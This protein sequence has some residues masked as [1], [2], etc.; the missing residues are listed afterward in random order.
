[1]RGKRALPQTS[2]ERGSPPQPASQERR[3]PKPSKRDHLLPQQPLLP[4]PPARKEQG[5]P[6]L[7]QTKAALPAWCFEHPGQGEREPQRLAGS[8]P[9][10]PSFGQA[11]LA[12]ALRDKMGVKR[13]EHVVPLHQPM[14]PLSERRK[15]GGETT[16]DSL[17]TLL[18]SPSAL[19]PVRPRAGTCFCC[20]PGQRAERLHH[21]AAINAA[22]ERGRAERSRPSEPLRALGR[23]FLSR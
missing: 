8:S 1:M 11:A 2:G 3:A 15:E 22:A 10:P 20:H 7:L 5:L 6:V 21:L 18:S 16:G 13:G 17:Q 12:G 4:Q 19:S 23:N 9:C 14:P